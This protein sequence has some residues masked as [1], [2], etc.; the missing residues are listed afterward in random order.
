MSPCR[1]WRLTWIRRGGSARHFPQ[2][3]FWEKG[4]TPYPCLGSRREPVTSSL[5]CE[6]VDTCKPDP[7]IYINRRK[8]TL[9]KLNK[10]FVCQTWMGENLIRNVFPK[11][12]RIFYDCLSWFWLF[13]WKL[14]EVGVR[15]TNPF[16]RA[17]GAPR[18]RGPCLRAWNPYT[19][20][21]GKKL[22]KQSNFLRPT[23]RVYAR[24]FW[25]DQNLFVCLFLHF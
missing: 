2:E 7:C 16:P 12:A 18:M 1:L 20:R 6:D 15:P 3:L 11:G 19:S 23:C 22:G 17:G 14:C 4:W 21:G 8:H 13:F 24:Y 10:D 25:T 5:F 9:Q